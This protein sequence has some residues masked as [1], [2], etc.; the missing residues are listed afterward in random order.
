MSG[1]LAG[2]S[3]TIADDRRSLARAHS[4]NPD[5]AALGATHPPLGP[6]PAA[7]PVAGP[8]DSSGAAPNVA[9]AAAT[10]ASAI[11]A[12][13]SAV[14]GRSSGRDKASGDAA[15][16]MSEAGE[17]APEPPQPPPAA[18]AA[19]AAGTAVNA[20]SAALRVPGL[21]A[22][23]QSRRVLLCRERLEFLCSVEESPGMP[24]PRAKFQVR[25]AMHLTRH[26]VRI[27][28]I[29][30]GWLASHV[31]MINAQVNLS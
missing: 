4:S 7:A 10:A 28:G 29:C 5:I 19:A 24:W 2:R 13:V 27:A 12:A 3:A 8:P 6:A 17:A 11:A 22:E 20:A 25:A 16:P 14:A 30:P 26:A 15:A 23:E 31:L 9:A 21:S 18:T 1:I